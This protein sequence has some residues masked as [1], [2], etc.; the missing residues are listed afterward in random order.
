MDVDRL[1]HSWTRTRL[2][3]ECISLYFTSFG[4]GYANYVN[5]AVGSKCEL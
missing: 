1:R 5:A 4:F 3:Q 2:S